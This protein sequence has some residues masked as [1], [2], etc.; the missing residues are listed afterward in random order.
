MILVTSNR[1]KYDWCKQKINVLIKFQAAYRI[2]GKA[3]ES[4]LENKM[5]KGGKQ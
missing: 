3:K 2:I 5:D 1:T 4:G